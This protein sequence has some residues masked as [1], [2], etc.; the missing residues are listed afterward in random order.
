MSG[1]ICTRGTSMKAKGTG[2]R[3]GKVSYGNRGGG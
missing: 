1:A 3:T 2:T